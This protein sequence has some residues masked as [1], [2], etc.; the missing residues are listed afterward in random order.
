MVRIRLV[1]ETGFV[2]G[3]HEDEIEVPDEEWNAM[4]PKE[5]EK[6]IEDEATVF[7]SN[8]ISYHGYVIEDDED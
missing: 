3:D 2:G 5:Q 6:F 1:V 7:M 8:C 4:S